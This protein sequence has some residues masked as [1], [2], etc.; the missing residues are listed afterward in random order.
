MY[1]SASLACSPPL[2]ISIPDIISSLSV[3]RLGETLTSEE[4]GNIVAEVGD[5]HEKLCTMVV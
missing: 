5:F 4:T 2:D 3:G 1:M